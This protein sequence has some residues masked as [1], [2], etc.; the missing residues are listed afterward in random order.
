MIEIKNIKTLRDLAD[1][2]NL[3]KKVS[4]ALLEHIINNGWFISRQKYY[5]AV[6]VEIF[7]A[8]ICFPSG[9][10]DIIPINCIDEHLPELPKQEDVA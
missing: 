1:Y 9:F 5:L 3:E 6:D 4:A 10:N 7:S 8:V 2:L